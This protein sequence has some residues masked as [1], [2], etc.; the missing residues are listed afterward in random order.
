[1]LICEDFYQEKDKSTQL[2]S[3]VYEKGPL[4]RETPMDIGG[5]SMVATQ[6]EFRANIKT[7]KK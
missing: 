3:L 6:S 5:R 1:L 2:S 4:S 7:E